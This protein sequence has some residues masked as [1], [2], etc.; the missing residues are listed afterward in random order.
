MSQVVMYMASKELMRE[1]YFLKEDK[2]LEVYAERFSEYTPAPAFEV[3]KSG[4]DAAEEAFD[5]TNNPSR[6]VDRRIAG[7]VNH[8]SLSTG[9]VVRV[10]GYDDVADYICKSFGWE[11]M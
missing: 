11:K 9:D 10:I 1:M 4:E 6:D 5:L 8:R 7:F 3:E 2:A